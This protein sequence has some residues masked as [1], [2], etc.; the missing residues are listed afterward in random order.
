MVHWPMLVL[1]KYFGSAWVVT[2]LFNCQTQVAELV[3]LEWAMHRE[4]CRPGCTVQ[5]CTP[6][7]PMSCSG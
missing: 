4:H 6:C 5:L 3:L 2:E 1:R 7:T